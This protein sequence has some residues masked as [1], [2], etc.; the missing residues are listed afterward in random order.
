MKKVMSIAIAT[1]LAL[2]ITGCAST[3]E[4]KA[5]KA[6]KERV[7][8]QEVA[9][10]RSAGRRAVLSTWSGEMK[11]CIS[12]SQDARSTQLASA[13]MRGGNIPYFNGADL[14]SGC[15]TPIPPLDYSSVNE[16]LE[17]TR[18][19][20]RERRPKQTTCSSTGY[21]VTNCTTY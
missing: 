5:R 17:D 16:G 3:P 2:V 1:A 11:Y 4:Q 18:R 7:W 21:G 13:C 20:L 10:C 8:A 14:F 9:Q 19:A 15:Q 12:K 6:A